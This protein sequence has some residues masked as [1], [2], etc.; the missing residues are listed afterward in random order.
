MPAR[1]IV[2]QDAILCKAGIDGLLHNY[3]QLVT[4]ASGMY[5]QT[6]SVQ[7]CGNGY[8]DRETAPVAVSTRYDVGD[9]YLE[10]LT[11]KADRHTSS[12]HP[13]SESQQIV[14]LPG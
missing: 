11:N 2:Y 12:D 6:W 1:Y 8:R 9:T 13:H 5:L 4:I 10:I 3:G 7:K 14:G